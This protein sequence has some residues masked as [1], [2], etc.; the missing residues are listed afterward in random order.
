MFSKNRSFAG[1]GFLKITIVAV[2]FT[3][4]GIL[5]AS[6]FN[7]SSSSHADNE[8][9]QI[10]KTIPRPHIL[11]GNESPFVAVADKVMPA[12]VNVRA[13][14]VVKRRIRGLP[15]EFYFEDPFEDFFRDFFRRPPKEDEGQEYEQRTEGRGSGVIIDQEGYILTNNHVVEGAEEVTI[16]LSDDREFK[17]EIVGTDPMTDIALLKIKE[18]GILNGDA[19][20]QLG[21]SDQIRIGDW[22]IAIGNPFGLDRT[23]TVGVISAKGRTGLHI[24]DSG[25]RDR[26][27]TFQDFIQTDASINFGNSGGPLVN[28]NGEVIGINTA[29]NTQG[30]GIGFAIPINVAKKISQQLKESGRVVRGFLGIWFTELSQDIIEAKDLD[31]DHGIIVDE[32]MENSPAEKAGVKQGDVVI[33]FDGKEIESGSQF[34]F[35]VAGTEPGKSVELELIR[36]G[37]R[38][39]VDVEL[40]ERE[41]EE[42]AQDEE[43]EEEAW[44]GLT[45][46]N[47]SRSYARQ[48]NLDDDKGVLVFEV[49]PGSPAD[50]KDI[51]QGDIILEVDNK[52]IEDLTEY[53]KVTGDLKDREKA[54]LF[55]VKRGE[56]VF[57]IALKPDKN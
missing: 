57:Y 26:S 40:G 15:F 38:K 1:L 30:Q 50:D 45:V 14:I 9:G 17:T 11:S 56:R 2:V 52:P 47:I 37:K 21:D 24:A 48:H 10:Q 36:D 44:L 13:E 16:K 31:V 35:T 49:E 19:V 51:R 54:I 29:I 3:G 20:A 43:P 6:S 55:L 32:V 8:P 53:R 39:T 12:V 28:I 23:V 18:N 27:P 25:G 41:T 42:T 34:Q 33:G 5:L 4:L 7:W 22:A 46:D